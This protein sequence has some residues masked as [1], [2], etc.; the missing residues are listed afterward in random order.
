VSDHFS[1]EVVPLPGG[2]LLLL[3]VAAGLCRW[4]DAQL[5]RMALA[6]GARECRF[7]VTIGRDTLERA[8][9]FE[10]FPGG[11]AALAEPALEYLLNPAVCYHA[12]ALFAGRRLG[13]TVLLTAR[14]SCFRESDRESGSPARLWEFTM[15]EVVFIGAAAWVAE[16]R[17]AWAARTEAWAAS[18]GLGGS[19]VPAVDPFFGAAGRGKRLLQQL[20]GLKLE[21]LL[22]CAGTPLAA[23]SFNLHGPFFGERFDIG[24]DGAAAHS[25]CAAF[26]LERWALAFLAQR[27]ERAA[28]ELIGA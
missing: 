14:Q 28:A 16:R 9:F 18:L 24:F 2:R 7:P 27:G 21:L 12:Y 1:A 3:G 22:D 13:E 4:L 6:D 23:A 17:G 11:A 20:E 10:S 5:L 26:G 15:R 8:E 25:G 19:L